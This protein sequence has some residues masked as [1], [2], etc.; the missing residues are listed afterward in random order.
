MT[1]DYGWVETL[2]NELERSGFEVTP[3]NGEPGRESAHVSID[4][5]NFFLTTFAE[6]RSYNLFRKIPEGGNYTTLP[7][8]PSSPTSIRMSYRRSDIKGLGDLIR[9]FGQRQLSSNEVIDSKTVSDVTGFSI[10]RLPFFAGTPQGR[11][12]SIAYRFQ[13]HYERDS[14]NFRMG[15]WEYKKDLFPYHVNQLADEG[16]YC[17]VS[18]EFPILPVDIAKVR[19]GIWIGFENLGSLESQRVRELFHGMPFSR[20]FHVEYKDAVIYADGGRLGLHN[21]FTVSEIPDIVS[22][23]QGALP[24]FMAFYENIRP[25]N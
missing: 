4:G 11:L 17:V 1:E 21:S 20:S 7:E 2:A 5:D 8:A 16:H 23:F 15:P 18:R 3:E 9:S 12:L 6:F 13:P 19:G 14:C 24:T 22:A 10:A 25:Y